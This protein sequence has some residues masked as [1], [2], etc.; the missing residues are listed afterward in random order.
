MNSRDRDAVC[1]LAGWA[2]VEVVLLDIDTI[3]GNSGQ[4]DVLVGDVVD[5][6]NKVSV[7]NT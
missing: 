6:N 1:W 4:S 7:L 3:V 2:A 5:L